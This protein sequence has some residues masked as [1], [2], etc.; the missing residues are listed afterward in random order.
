M[1]KDWIFWQD[2]E[3]KYKSKLVQEFLKV[4]KVKVLNHP[5][6]SPDINPIENLWDALGIRVAIKE[7]FE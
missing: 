6:Q 5:E 3:P 7:I 4:R 1:P 2:Y